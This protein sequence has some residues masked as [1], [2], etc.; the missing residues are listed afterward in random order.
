M[1]ETLVA[2]CSEDQVAKPTFFGSTQKYLAILLAL[3]AATAIVVDGVKSELTRISSLARVNEKC[4][5]WGEMTWALSDDETS[6]MATLREVL[7]ELR[8][9]RRGTKA[10][11]RA[12][13]IVE[14]ST[15]AEDCRIANIAMIMLPK[16]ME[17]LKLNK[18]GEKEESEHILM[19]RRQLSCRLGKGEERF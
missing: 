6:A 12:P 9:Q 11:A 10:A 19:M 5:E 14:E 2:A 15:T 13:T 7:V 17:T 8:Q 16:Y 4:Q 18:S 1:V 3:K